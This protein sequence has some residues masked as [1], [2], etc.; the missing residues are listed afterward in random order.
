MNESEITERVS[1]D[2]Y[3]PCWSCGMLV[4]VK[5]VKCRFCGADLPPGVPLSELA[6]RVSERLRHA[7]ELQAQGMYEHDMLRTAGRKIRIMTMLFWGGWD[8]AS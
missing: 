2:E 8:Y 3:R 6:Q 5:A 4:R 1:A 7:D